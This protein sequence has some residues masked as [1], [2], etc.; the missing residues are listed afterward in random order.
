MKILAPYV[1]MCGSFASLILLYGY[2]NTVFE[3]TITVFLILKCVK[4]IY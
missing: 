4:E 2:Y 3:V 1:N